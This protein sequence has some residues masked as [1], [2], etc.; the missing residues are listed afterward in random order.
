M[1]NLYTVCVCAG[2]RSPPSSSLF[3]FQAKRPPSL[4]FLPWAG[5]ET[6]FDILMP[7]LKVR[8]EREER[9]DDPHI[10]LFLPAK[11][12]VSIQQNLA[13]EFLFLPILSGLACTVIFIAVLMGFPKS[14]ILNIFP[15]PNFI[16]S[17]SPG[18]SVSDALPKI[19]RLLFPTASKTEKII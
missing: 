2:Y 15:F 7:L 12:L 3:T 9:E 10:S 1:S 8:G 19:P 4:H 16:Y 5:R 18:K 14:H 13:P 6:V 17:I 11:S